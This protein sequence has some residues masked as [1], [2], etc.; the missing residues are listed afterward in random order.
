MEIIYN[1]IFS[2]TLIFLI[3]YLYDFFKSNLSTPIV[4]DYV[5]KPDIEYKKIYD[6]LKNNPSTINN[7]KEIGTTSINNLEMPN[8]EISN[9]QTN[10]MKNEL[11]SFLANLENDNEIMDVN[12]TNKSNEFSLG[13]ASNNFSFMN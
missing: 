8:T 4:K 12:S 11:K 9:N 3:H 13:E 1:I 6:I 2:I 10:D 5:K 7:N